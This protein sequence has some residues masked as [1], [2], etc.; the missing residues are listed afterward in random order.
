LRRTTRFQTQNKER[1]MLVLP[2]KS[3]EAVVVSRAGGENVILAQFVASRAWF[4]RKVASAG[5]STTGN[6]CR[7]R[8]M[9]F[10][11][12]LAALDMPWH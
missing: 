5:V 1:I 9:L 8:F 11:G 2:R 4:K 3:Q 7:L 10:F 12:A 6:E